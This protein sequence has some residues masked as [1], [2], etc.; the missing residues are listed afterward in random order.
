VVYADE[1]AY[2]E[3]IIMSTGDLSESKPTARLG[4]SGAPTEIMDM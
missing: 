4:R 2:L 1:I 3:V